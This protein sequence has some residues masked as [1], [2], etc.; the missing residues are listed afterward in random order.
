MK[1]ANDW[2]KKKKRT[3]ETFRINAAKLKSQREADNVMTEKHEGRQPKRKTVIKIFS[4]VVYWLFNCRYSSL[5][6]WYCHLICWY[7]FLIRW[8]WPLS[9]WYCSLGCRYWPFTFFGIYLLLFE[10][11]PFCWWNSSI[12][13]LVWISFLLNWTFVFVEI[14]L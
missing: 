5:S 13:L 9:C 14:D 4:G 10:Y 12:H 11:W 6:C 1:C 2:Y 3:S 8:Y 7:Y